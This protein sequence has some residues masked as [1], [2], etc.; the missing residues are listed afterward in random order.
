MNKT[1]FLVLDCSKSRRQ[2]QYY[3]NKRHCQLL[4]IFVVLRNIE[5]KHEFGELLSELLDKKVIMNYCAWLP[6]H[7]LSHIHSMCAKCGNEKQGLEGG[8]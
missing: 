7:S 4:L 2:K 8:S 5:S 1:T 3:I 6:S